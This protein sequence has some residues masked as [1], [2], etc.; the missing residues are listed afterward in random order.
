[1]KASTSLIWKEWRETRI[2]LWIGLGVFLGLPL[3]GGIEAAMRH[4]GPRFDI[5]VELF[6]IPLGGVLAIFVAVGET[7][8]DFDGHIADFWRARPVG[9]IRWML[10][11][12]L[13]GLVVVI[14]SCAMP[15]LVQYCLDRESGDLIVLI[16]FPFLW[17]AMYS[18]GFLAGC[19]LRRTAH[20]ATLALGVMLLVWFL[21]IILRSLSW[22]NIWSVLD[23]GTAVYWDP[24]PLFGRTLVEFGVGMLVLSA[25][26][27]AAALLAVRRDWVIESSGKMMY[28]TIAGAVLLFLGSLV[29]QLGT[30]LP[31][32]Q[33]IELRQ[34]E[35]VRDIW[36]SG[37]QYFVETWMPTPESY[38]EYYRTLRVT[39]LGIELGPPGDIGAVGGSNAFV[40]RISAPG[41]ADIGYRA[42][43]DADSLAE[44]LQVLSHP[45][46]SIVASLPLWKIDAN[47]QNRSR[48]DAD[49]YAWQDR[50][51]V[52]KL[53]L[54]YPTPEGWTFS[55][56]GLTTF[57]IT[58][59]RSPRL[60]SDGPIDYGRVFFN[61]APDEIDIPLPPI[62]DMPAAERLKAALGNGWRLGQ[63]EGDVLLLQ[64]RELSEYRL[65]KITDAVATFK[66]VGDFRLPL[67]SDVFGKLGYGESW[68]QNGLVYASTVVGRPNAQSGVNP[69][70]TVFDTRSPHPFRA[71][72]HFAAPGLSAVC[73]LPDGRTIAAGGNKIWLLGPPPR[74]AGN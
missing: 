36:A 67:L 30:N 68:L 35:Q 44:L 48:A 19:L 74:P 45:D 32:L 49:L 63:F 59:P 26:A 18:I 39:P 47:A 66:K 13:V 37:E 10:I 53:S 46:N 8:R 31:V 62:P 24:Q 4:M 22:M 64:T 60:I 58:D 70:I 71:V 65:T 11:K 52:M 73:P 61:V 29:L 28:G 69:S 57:D 56:T 41:S 42:I 6:V 5:P 16:W 20:A 3:I 51:Y 12:Y 72:G 27:L 9:I 33:Q 2:Y 15:L 1:M 43:S 7:C 23:V 17:A 38:V 14:V 25:T 21:P 54:S 55:F 50:L 34:D 40:R